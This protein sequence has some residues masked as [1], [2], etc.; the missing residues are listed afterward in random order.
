MR[1]SWPFSKVRKLEEWLRESIFRE[2]FKGIPV[3]ETAFLPEE[4][5]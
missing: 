3:T 2:Q 4:F 5:A 1:G